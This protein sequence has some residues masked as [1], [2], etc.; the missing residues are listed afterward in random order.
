MISFYV[1][2]KMSDTVIELPVLEI[3]LPLEED[4]SL[5]SPIAE[6]CRKWGFFLITNHGVSEELYSKLK[7]LCKQLF[8]LPLDA[9]LK[10]GPLSSI[11]S[12]TPHFIASPFF[13]SLRV[14]GPDFFSSAQGSADVIFDRKKHEFW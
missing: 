7:N 13:E 3:S 10:L 5:L 6:A 2:E 8:S 12:Y 9:K 1:T 14:S 11:K 4:Q